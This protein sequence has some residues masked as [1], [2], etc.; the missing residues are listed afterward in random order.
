MLRYVRYKPLPISVPPVFEISPVSTSVQLGDE[1]TLQ[2]A[3]DGYPTPNIM[4]EHYS[5]VVRENAGVEINVEIV[6]STTMST[7]HITTVQ[8]DNY[9][10]YTCRVNIVLVSEPATISFAGKCSR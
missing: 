8:T 7:L 1:V 2:C 6:N 10:Q 3:V 4:W 5:T 9:G